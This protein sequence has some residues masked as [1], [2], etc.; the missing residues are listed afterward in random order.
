MSFDIHALESPQGVGAPLQLGS[1]C[2]LS[3]FGAPTNATIPLLLVEGHKLV[4]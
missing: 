4:L 3:Q 1:H 2:Q